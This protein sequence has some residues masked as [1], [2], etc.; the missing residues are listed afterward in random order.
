MVT[1]DIGR[2]ITTATKNVSSD[3][4]LSDEER[5]IAQNIAP[6]IRQS[7]RN[8]LPIYVRE[9]STHD[10]Q[11]IDGLAILEATKLAEQKVIYCIQVDSSPESE[12]QIIKGQQILTQ[13]N[14]TGG[15]N[16]PTASYDSMPLMKQMEAIVKVL[17]SQ[18]EKTDQIHAHVVPDKTLSVNIED[19]RS[20]KAKLFLVPGIGEATLPKVVGDIIKN[21]PFYSEY[22]FKAGVTGF[23]PP[24]TKSKAKRPKHEQLW[25][26]L[27]EEYVLDWS[28]SN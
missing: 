9:I 10:Y 5:A 26:D 22:E 4:D 3:R 8:W 14:Q 24:K 2:L 18:V 13:T 11:L 28:V 23:K 15:G 1:R 21:R 19:E 25:K 17:N 6:L 12:E 16:L 27:T 7:Q 20:L